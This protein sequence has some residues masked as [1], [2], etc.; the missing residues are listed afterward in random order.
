MEILSQV[1]GINI[2]ARFISERNIIPVFGAGFTMKSSAYRGSVPDGSVATSMM[3]KM[4]VDHC[5]KMNEDDV[6]DM[7]FNETSE[8][9]I[10]L[11]P[12]DIRTDFF[13]NYF[14]EVQLGTQQKELL[15][16][17]WPYAYTLNVSWK[18]SVP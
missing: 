6:K 9:F 10:D 1:D 2:L 5:T 15:Q 14:T 3:K 18:K 8:L 4:L 7:D 17:N 12:K 16:F 13:K 11:V